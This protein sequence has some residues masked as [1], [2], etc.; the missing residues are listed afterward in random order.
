MKKRKEKKKIKIKRNQ[1][2][3][4][5]QNFN[6]RPDNTCKRLWINDVYKF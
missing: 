3:S 1:K 6:L 4:A 5:N 2:L